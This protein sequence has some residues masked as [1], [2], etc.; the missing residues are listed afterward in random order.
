MSSQW[1][2]VHRPLLATLAAA[3]EPLSVSTLTTMAGLDDPHV[4]SVLCRRRFRPFLTAISGPEG[5]EIRYSIYHASLREFRCGRV[6]PSEIGGDEGWPEDAAAAVTGAHSRMADVYLSR[7]GGLAAGMP[8]L[9]RD[10]VLGF[11]DSG[12]PLRFLVHHLDRAG[13]ESDIHALLACTSPG[14]DGSVGTTMNVWFAAHDH[15]GTVADY[16]NDL[17]RIRSVLRQRNDELFE[18]RNSA[19]S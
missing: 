17:G 7:F 16:A 2:S 14:P 12:Y 13:R 9:A 15:A 10:P 5:S 4:V 1:R 18:R 6:D 8:E 19:W 3:G 11:L